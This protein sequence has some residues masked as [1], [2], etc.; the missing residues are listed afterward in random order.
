MNLRETITLPTRDLY[1]SRLRCLMLTTLPRR[2]VAAALQ[3][4]VDPL[5]E[6]NPDRHHWTPMG[7]LNSEE[8]KL[9][10]CPNFLTPE[11]RE[12]LT[13]WWLVNRRGANT[14]NWDIVSTCAI[15]GREGLLL[16]EAKAHDTEARR[17][18]KSK[19]DAENDAR[20][21]TAIAEANSALL[22]TSSGW[23]ISRETH[24]QLSNR[25]AWAWKVASLGVPVI[26]VY[27]GFLN[28]DE[29]AHRGQPFTSDRKWRTVMLNH[30]ANLV[31]ESAWE[32]RLQTVQAPMWA[33]LR[34]MELKWTVGE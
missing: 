10:E 19:G 12:Q 14:P 4:L 22:G 11:L 18:G 16:I 5:G 23:A 15:E 27:L 34:T 24:Y 17:E 25:F 1:G 8:A 20:I 32:A 30:S 9:G 13:S 6:V 7:L 33:L 28:A 2:S 21:G 3:S 31:P 29:M 26:L